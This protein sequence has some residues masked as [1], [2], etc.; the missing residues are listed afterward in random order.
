MQ[1]R[2]IPE[3]TINEWVDYIQTVHHRE[4]ELSLERVNEVY[5]RLYPQ[6]L[7]CKV[8]SVA[9]TNGKGSTA[10]IIASIYHQA[11]YSVGKFSSPHLVEFGERYSIN[12]ANASKQALLDAF[13]K[14][15]QARAEIP[16]TYF[17]FGA[18][19]A[20]ELFSSANVD[21]AV[22]E[23]GLGGRLSWHRSVRKAMHSRNQAACK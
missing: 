13:N 21:V 23:V 17:E 3:R 20:I 14:I 18:L 6:G 22:M 1:Q 4:I 5:R 15:E 19:L 8:I 2:L 10:E 9:G 11:G 16:I 12:G 7:D